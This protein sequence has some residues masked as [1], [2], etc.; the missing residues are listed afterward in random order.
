MLDTK[1]D[2]SN[3]A[4]KDSGRRKIAES[5]AKSIDIIS[6]L[7]QQSKSQ[8]LT[9]ISIFVIAFSAYNWLYDR[10]EQLENQIESKI[11]VVQTR[12]SS[13]EER[14]NQHAI[15]LSN[16]ELL[17]KVYHPENIER[18]RVSPAQKADTSKK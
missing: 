3:P 18:L 15:V 5:I 1:H 7:P 9:L 14:Q 13:L 10:F 17:F 12:V 16:H 6:E 11:E 4:G 2:P 8:S